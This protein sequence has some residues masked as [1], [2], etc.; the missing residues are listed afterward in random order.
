MFGGQLQIEVTL[1]FPVGAHLLLWDWLTYRSVHCQRKDSALPGFTTRERNCISSLCPNSYE[2]K[3][4]KKDEGN[5]Y[6]GEQQT[7]GLGG[8]LVEGKKEKMR[9]TPG[10]VGGTDPSPPSNL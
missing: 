6:Y 5:N 3:G 8:L 7:L 4:G 1:R 10:T 9:E 2:G